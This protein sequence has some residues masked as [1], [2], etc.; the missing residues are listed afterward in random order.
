MHQVA[1]TSSGLDSAPQ[2]L[3]Q[4]ACYRLDKADAATSTFQSVSGHAKDAA[5]S[6]LALVKHLGAVPVETKA[7]SRC[8]AH[9]KL[10]CALGLKNKGMD[11]GK[12]HPTWALYC[13]PLHYTC[14]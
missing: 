13:P 4:G 7:A 6:G 1:E 12:I 8:R 3:R 10:C 14:Q 2:D 11:G 9:A 5:R